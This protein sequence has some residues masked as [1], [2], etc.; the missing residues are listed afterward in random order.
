MKD[1]ASG[2]SMR[3]IKLKTSDDF[4]S[5]T[6]RKAPRIRGPSDR[7]GRKQAIG[8]A[9]QSPCRFNFSFGLS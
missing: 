8:A 2:L 5:E 6:A 7:E 1:A 4:S 9:V 3:R